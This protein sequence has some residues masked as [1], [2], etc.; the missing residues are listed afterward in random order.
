[1]D[2]VNNFF[3][4]IFKPSPFSFLAIFYLACLC[5]RHPR[6][7]LRMK[8]WGLW[9]Q[10]LSVQDCSI[11]CHCTLSY[12]YTPVWQSKLDGLGFQQSFRI[13]NLLISDLPR[14]VSFTV[15]PKLYI[16]KT[17][18]TDYLLWH[19]QLIGCAVKYQIMV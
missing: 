17:L 3:S 2:R 13:Q 8:K 6:V 4:R 14:E 11:S 7:H 19:T 15:R 5:T 18:N 9:N 16:P 1:M 12:N 10:H